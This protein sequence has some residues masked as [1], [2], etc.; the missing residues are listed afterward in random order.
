M[1]DGLP[2]VE[3]DF[4]AQMQALVIEAE[5]VLGEKSPKVPDRRPE[6]PVVPNGPS[7]TQLLRPLLLGMESLMRKQADHTDTLERVEKALGTQAT[8]PDVLNEARQSLD[9]RNVVNR[10][11]FDAL[12][13]ELKRYKDDFVLESLVRPMVR[14]LIMIYDDA[15]EIH[16]QVA[17][18]LVEQ[19]EAE[20]SPLLRTLRTLGKNLEHHIHYVLEVLE[21]M[22]VQVMPPHTGQLDKRN[23]KVVAREP[24]TNADED[25]NVVRS[26]RP[27]FLWRGRL[28]RPEE[29]II[30]KWAG[31]PEPPS[32]SE[33]AETASS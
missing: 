11:M 3:L 29:V 26:V 7:L 10:A 30:K 16:R 18:V 6:A 23:Q 21:R 13:S 24:A 14:D 28:F 8:I 5:Q 22:E 12:H 9:Q 31:S 19:S 32:D 17:E 4:S 1:P 2:D 20:R 33:T 25:L 27:G 15:R